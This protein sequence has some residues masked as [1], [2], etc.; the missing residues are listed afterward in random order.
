[1]C[2]IL[3]F[4]ILQ[5]EK[6]TSKIRTPK[7]SLNSVPANDFFGVRVTTSSLT[8]VSKN[9]V[10]SA[11]KVQFEKNSHSINK[12]MKTRVLKAELI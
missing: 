6:L 7:L 9:S 11:N 4:I 1:M 12:Y 8:L 10:R 2:Q 5:H 3:Y